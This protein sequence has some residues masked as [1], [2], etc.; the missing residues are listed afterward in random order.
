MTGTGEFVYKMITCKHTGKLTLSTEII[1]LIFI[2]FE[3]C[4]FLNA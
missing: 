4:Q 2:Q 1:N 3:I